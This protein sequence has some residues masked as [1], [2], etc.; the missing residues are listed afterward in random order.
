MLAKLQEFQRVH[1]TPLEQSIR[2]LDEAF[3]W[4]PKSAYAAPAKPLAELARQKRRGVQRISD[5]M[6]S[7]LLRLGVSL[8]EDVASKTSA[9][10]EF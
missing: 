3:A 8:E 5:L 4:L 9:E 1:K 6:I 10:A 2:D 7:L